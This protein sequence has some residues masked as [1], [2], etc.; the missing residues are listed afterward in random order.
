LQ[1]TDVYSKRIVGSKV[2]IKSLRKGS[3]IVD[4]DLVIPDSPTSKVLVVDTV[5]KLVNGLVFV[6]FSGEIVNVNTASIEHST[7]GEV[8]ITNSSDGCTVVNSQGACDVGY[9]CQ[10]FVN[11]T[12]ACMY[13]QLF[14]AERNQ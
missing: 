5:Y 12:V 1:L 3:L 2:I 11:L 9:T 4:F 7:Y 10:E 13:V 6:N 8:I 14:I